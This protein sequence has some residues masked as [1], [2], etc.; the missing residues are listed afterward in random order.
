MSGMTLPEAMWVERARTFAFFV[1]ALIV[2]AS[3]GVLAA[4]QAHAAT[5]FTVNF[6]G[7]EN[8]TGFPN[9]NFTGSSDG[10]CDFDSGRTPVH[11]EGGHPAGQR[12]QR[13]RHH[14]V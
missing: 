10:K 6:T 13:S 8:D 9:G 1:L 14:S 5:T 7:D 4:N 3:I 2:A 11:P 12:H